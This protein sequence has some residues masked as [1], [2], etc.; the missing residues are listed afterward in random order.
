MAEAARFLGGKVSGEFQLET[1]S[2]KKYGFLEP[3]NGKLAVTTRAKR[4]IRPQ[5]DTDELSAIREAVLDA[6]E[7]SDVYN[8]YR[9]EYLPDDEFFS[10]ALTERFKIPADKLADFKEVFTDS[11]K[12]AQLI[13]G[14]G[15]RPKLIDV[16][17]EDAVRSPSA[18]GSA[19]KKEDHSTPASD[20]S[21]FVMQPFSPPYDGYYDM[22]FRPA[23][24]QAGL[25]PVRADDEIF[26]SGKIM[27]QVWRGIREAKVLLAELTTRNANVYY[28]L[29]SCSRAGQTRCP[30]RCR[31]R[32]STIRCASYPRCLLRH[33]RSIL[34]AKA[35]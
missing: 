13:D 33:Q 19:A 22:V 29:R 3:D 30:S 35:Y 6:P 14:T 25:R 24:A 31:R 12:A 20:S 28:E 9:G 15:I 17:R 34:G 7:I 2:A 11:L 4:A 8:F 1:S 18:P 23:I 5:S 16:G 21:C 10:N 26:G 27:D 32:R